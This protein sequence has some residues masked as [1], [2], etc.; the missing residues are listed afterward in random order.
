MSVQLAGSVIYLLLWLPLGVFAWYTYRRT[1]PAAPVPA[2]LVLTGLRVAIAGFLLLLLT[3]PLVN[4]WRRR[5][6]E[7]ALLVLLDVSTSMNLAEGDSTRLERVNDVLGQPALQEALVGVDVQAFGFADYIM[8][9]SLDTVGALV[10]DGQATD[11]ASA[12]SAALEQS[13]NR[14]E[15]RGILILSD[16]RHNVGPDPVRGAAESGVPIYALSTGGPDHPPDVQIVRTE[17]AGGAYVGQKLEL[18]VEVRA[19]HFAGRRTTVHL[20]E[21]ERR[22]D[23]A[24]VTLGDDGQIVTVGLGHTPERGGPHLYRVVV[25]ALEGESTT[26]N[27]EELVY[28][29]VQEERIRVLLLGAAPGAELAFLR[30]ALESDSRVNLE[31]PERLQAD[32]L[33]TTLAGPEATLAEYDVVVMVDPGAAALQGEPAEAL[34]AWVESGGGMLMLF[35]LHTVRDWMAGSP[36][37][38]LL[39]FELPARP[40]L[41]SEPVRLRMSAA[42]GNH[43]VTRQSEGSTHADPWTR[44]PPL[45]GY[46]QAAAVRSG[47][48]TLLETDE[49]DGMPVVMA[50]RAG[51]GRVVAVLA[52]GFWRT[53][54]LAS[55]TGGNPEVVRRLWR[56]AVQWLSRAGNGGRVRVWSESPVYRSGGRLEFAGQVFDELLRPQEGAE[57]SLELE[58]GQVSIP[59]LDQGG[60]HYRA[61]WPTPEPGEYRFTASAAVA[62]REIGQ[63]EGHFVVEP[64]TLESVDMRANPELLAEMARVS[65][66]VALPLQHWAELL[67]HMPLQRRVQRERAVYSLWPLSWSLAVVLVLLVLEWTLRKRYGMI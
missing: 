44:L 29:D 51:E 55:G 16:G 10:A 13:P 14:A 28:V 41:S 15:V 49:D 23:S 37:A 62:G 36:V 20:Y 54:L 65:G 66:G 53:E 4:R 26:D 24:E 17:L 63:D 43:P 5:V 27:N 1:R 21:S 45:P 64:Y 52:G 58:P 39:P 18:Q 8:P 46:V 7:P 59:L 67:E 6:V 3:E 38:G 47:A 33:R 19:W 40:Y 48:T 30:R 11:V 35:G 31:L 60:G 34:T 22:F 61:Q 32:M 50:D 42:A 57:V 12:V 2:T 56:N 9:V 25:E